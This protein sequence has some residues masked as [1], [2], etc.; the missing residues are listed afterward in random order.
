MNQPKRPE[1]LAPA[2]SPDALLAALSAGADA[3]YLG[4]SAFSNRM[5][6]RNFS[7]DELTEALQTARYAGAASY[8]TVNTRVRPEE[9][10][11]VLH[12][13]EHLLKHHCT[14]FIV[15]DAGVAAILHSH[16]PEAVL[17]ASTQMTL[18]D[19]AD[20]LALAGLGFTRM[21][22]PREISFAELRRLTR[23]CPLEIEMFLHGAHCVSLSGQCL[24]SW[25]MGGRSGNRG[26]CA[27]PCRLPYTAV[28]LGNADAANR[29][30]WQDKALRKAPGNTYPLSLKDMC[31]AKWIPE[32]IDSGVAS[33]KIEGRQKPA[34]YVYG[35]TKIY[36]RLLD[37]G[38]AASEDEIAELDTFFSRDGFTDGYFASAERK[39]PYSHM[40]GVRASLAEL[41]GN[42]EK[43]KTEE[44]YT[45]PTREITGHC[46]V[47]AGVPMELTLSD[48][49]TGLSVT[50]EGEIP[51]TATGNPLTA[52][53]AA[54]NLCKFGGTPFH[55]GISPE[56]NAGVSI[57]VDDGL[58][59]PVSSLNALRRKA[60]ERLTDALF[61]EA[62]IRKGGEYRPAVAVPEKSVGNRCPRTAQCMF[63]DQV[64]DEALRY[65]TR[66]YLP[67]GE[68]HSWKVS[69]GTAENV[70]VTLP[71]V[72][73][74]DTDQTIR[75]LTESGCPFVQVHSPGQLYSAKKAGLTAHGSFRLNLWNTDSALF[76]YEMGAA[77]LTASPE[78]TITMLRQMPV[79][80][81]VYGHIP[82]MHT[83]RCFLYGKCG[84]IGGRIAG[85]T[86]PAEGCLGVLTDRTSAQFP[87]LAKDG[88]CEICNG[89]PL[90]MGDKESLLPPL[91]HREFLFTV[92]TAA[93]VD[94]VIRGYRKG[95]KRA[96]KRLR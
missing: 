35:V 29:E 95:E 17:H 30:K 58:W 80:A 76:W 67:L 50:A 91:T 84:G 66:I 36:R 2:G 74:G 13:A 7:E 71:A 85:K 60:V 56:G 69:G 57:Q 54:K 94:D 96:G 42:T 18:S 48:T 27:Q 4:A 1:L 65:F 63:A 5:R 90:W 21:V 32:I 9:M 10:G 62:V 73:F 25:A 75:T 37:E 70:G 46:T 53:S 55:M 28:R 16:F 47:S 23:E 59:C 40:L 92:E 24:M 82:L 93:Q 43:T 8:I 64:T 31:L 79:G 68:W 33:L 89:L 88:I 39:N 12:L 87:V 26:E 51:Q 41:A 78:A 52:E 22:V 14:G 19:P 6:A 38:R 20:G 61:P 11:D 83:S 44:K 34:A 81:I 72:L 3:V 45:L 49:K 86:C 77:T 15:A